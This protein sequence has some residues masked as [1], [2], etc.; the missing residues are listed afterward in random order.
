MA[1]EDDIKFLERVPMLRLIGRA[2]L[3]II[4]IG[5]ETRYVHGGEVLFHRDS[6]ADSGYVVQE[7]AFSLTAD[8]T[9]DPVQTAG[10]GTLLAEMS[11]M[12]E[13]VHS[14]TATASTP[15]TVMRIPRSLFLKTLDG[16]PDA[17]R[18]IRDHVLARAQQTERDLTRLHAHMS[19]S[20]R[21]Q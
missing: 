9:R 1:I 5:A 14:M 10:P 13:T 4:S 18:R 20:S 11:L 16:Y 15:S 2:G 3:R 17:A 8:P 21:G 12:A 7:G 19:S 6:H